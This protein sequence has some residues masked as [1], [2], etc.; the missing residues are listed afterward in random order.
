[1]LC[2]WILAA[3]EVVPL[4]ARLQVVALPKDGEAAVRDADSHEVGA[5]Q[6]G[7][8]RVVDALELGQLDFVEHADLSLQAQLEQSEAS[9]DHEHFVQLVLPLVQIVVVMVVVLNVVRVE[10]IQLKR[11]DFTRAWG[12]DTFL[13]NFNLRA[14]LFGVDEKLHVKERVAGGSIVPQCEVKIVVESTQDLELDCEVTVDQ[15]FNLERI[16]QID[17]VQLLV[18]LNQQ[19][20]VLFTLPVAFVLRLHKEKFP[21]TS[22]KLKEGRIALKAHLLR[23]PELLLIEGLLEER[24]LVVDKLDGELLLLRFFM[25]Q[26]CNF[27]ILR[28]NEDVNEAQE[29]NSLVVDQTIKETD[30]HLFG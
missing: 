19:G 5:T 2:L 30:L 17:V 29:L 28:V 8:H 1:M 6:R 10:R 24:I 27:A 25:D 21:G 26:V 22:Q 15:V 16:A 11:Q 18:C 13:R 12:W 4:V 23:G 3:H 7:L 20:K 9:I 14:M